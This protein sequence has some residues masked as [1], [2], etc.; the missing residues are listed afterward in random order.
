MFLTSYETQIYSDGP[1]GRVTT[2]LKST[3]LKKLTQLT[4]SKIRS[5]QRLT[6]FRKYNM[7]RILQIRNH[8]ATYASNGEYHGFWIDVEWFI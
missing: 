3:V 4:E 7:N 5:N 8:S 2:K 1:A 6:L